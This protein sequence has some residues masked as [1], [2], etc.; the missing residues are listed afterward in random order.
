M[1]TADMHWRACENAD[2]ERMQLDLAQLLAIRGGRR[3]DTRHAD[4]HGAA[5]EVRTKG[6]RR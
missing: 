3:D 5:A 1:Q 6:I 2:L 4:T